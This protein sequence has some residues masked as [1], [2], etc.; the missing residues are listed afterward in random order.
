MNSFF[1]CMIIM[2]YDNLKDQFESDVCDMVMEYFEDGN[3]T[4]FCGPRDKDE[5]IEEFLQEKFNTVLETKFECSEF[6]NGD[7]NVYLKMEEVA[8]KMWEDMM[9]E[10]YPDRGLVRIVNIW[11]YFIAKEYVLENYDLMLEHYNHETKPVFK[12]QII[13]TTGNCSV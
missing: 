6:I 8:C 5:V 12:S 13:T 7:L 11:K 9:D 10:D 1:I 3:S 2:N 4:D